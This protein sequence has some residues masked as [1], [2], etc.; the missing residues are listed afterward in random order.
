MANKKIK[1]LLHMAALA[2]IVMKGEMREYFDRKVKKG[3]NK[4]AVINGHKK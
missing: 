1:T 4:I 2:S 3:K